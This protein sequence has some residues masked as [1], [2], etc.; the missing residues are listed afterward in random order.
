[1]EPINGTRAR[2]EVG[3]N[4]LVP[5]AEEFLPPSDGVW[6]P[7]ERTF[8]LLPSND[9]LNAET[10]QYVEVALERD[11]AQ[12]TTVGIRW[13]HQDVDNQLVALFGFNPESPGSLVDHYYV[14]NAGG[15]TAEGFGVMFSHLLGGRVWG[16]SGIPI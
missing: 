7:P 1:M 12:A 15:V 5:G 2:V 8:A 9:S 6:L 14:T 3:R 11:L 16:V 10:S 13:F 4:V